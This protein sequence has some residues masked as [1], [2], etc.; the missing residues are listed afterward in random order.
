MSDMTPPGT[1]G[2]E[3]AALRPVPPLD[4]AATA[5]AVVDAHG[6]VTGWSE[7]AQRL[8]GHPA[9]AVI[10]RPAAV[11]LAGDP[12]TGTL[13]SLDGVQRWNGTATLRHRDGRILPV[14][15]LAHRRDLDS[16]VDGEAHEWLLV[17][18]VSRDQPQPDEDV[19]IGW[20]L[21]QSPCTMALYDTGLRLLRAN[22]D[23]ERVMGLSEAEMRGLRVSEIV[24]DPQGERTEELMRRVVAT[25]EQQHLQAALQLAGDAHESVW[26][27]SLAPVRDPRG[28]VRG[29]LLSAHDMTDQH[30][31]RQ[32]LALVA[33]AGVRIG[34]TL[35]LARTAREMADVA[36]GELADFV[37]VDL[38]PDID[39]DQEP[40]ATT[41]PRPVELRRVAN[42]SVLPGCPEAVVP[43]G[44]VAVYPRSS[45]AAEC[46]A[47][48]QP[49]IQQV[50]PT[51]V[52]RWAS[53]APDRAERMQRFGFHSVLAVPM[54]ARGVTLGV[55]TFSRHRRPEPFEQDDLLLAREITARAALSIDN[56]R[57]Y[58]RERDTSLTLQSSL[59]PQRLPRQSA[60]EV[61][62]RYLPADAQV[63][64]GGDWFDV[65]PLSGARVALVVGDVVGHGI[66]ASASMGRLRTAVRTLADVDLSPD[67]LLTHLDDLVNRLSA[68][69]DDTS[70]IADI[71]ATCLYAVYDPVSRR[72]TLARAGHPEP[73]LLR[74]GG[75]AR[76]L[77]L[78]A[79]P[80]LGLGGLP[81]EAVEVELPPG[82]L[83]VLHTD[84][85]IEAR[86]RDIDDGIGLL[87]RALDRSGPALE[88][89]CDAVVRDVLPTRPDDDVALLM[90]RTRALDSAHVASWDVPPHPS[91]VAD[92]RDRVN[93]QL[94]Q[95]GLAEAAFVTELVVSELVTNAIR[96]GE[97]PIQLR[98]ILDRN[99]IC[100][101]SDASSTAPHMRRA[102]VYDEGG[103]G[104]LL[105]A[106]L[107]QRW[108]TRHTYRGKTIWAEHA[109]PAD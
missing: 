18:P 66:Q 75:A 85:L 13:R 38:L 58:T 23:M 11:L 40:R 39:D 72:C 17:A 32:R 68:E 91:A 98:L 30:R 94:E 35:D 24:L 16:G 106:Q 102:R 8:V 47:S 37:T 9:S 12:P 55:A 92:I 52:D 44:S 88:D 105:V 90:A 96:Y 93:R 46:L 53:Q 65:I 48:G 97:P 79:G 56:A 27:V 20:S 51:V 84:G 64:V 109:L 7:G 26:S 77:E 104:L 36:V 81:F 71:G 63:G 76:V 25:G 22:A 61:A 2:D 21:I 54:R 50:T 5:R 60:V 78:P 29:V 28:T 4:E 80:P 103:R 57:R 34:T 107:C 42:Q 70:G 74:P 89:I 82:S 1:T 19:L 33:E 49:L 99:L 108:G 15:L 73:V 43:L 100:E 10:G 86:G 3:G 59:L 83:L 45:P 67:E 14:T 62:S 69:N 41:M 6:T 95:W 101:V 87:L 31:A